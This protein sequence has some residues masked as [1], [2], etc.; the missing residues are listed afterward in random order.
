MHNNI[1]SD[2][3][4]KITSLREARKK[5]A[6]HGVITALQKEKTNAARS[7]LFLFIIMGFLS[8]FTL[9][10]AYRYYRFAFDPTFPGWSPV[11]ATGMAAVTEVGK[12]MLSYTALSA[13]F[14]GWM[15]RSYSKFFA[16]VFALTI[17]GAWYYWSY[18]VSTE[19]MNLYAADQIAVSLKQDPLQAK[20]TAATADIDAQIADLKASDERAGKMTTKRGKIAWTGQSTIQ[21]NAATLSTLNEQRMIIVEATTKEHLEQGDKIEAKTNVLADWVKRFGGY[22][23]WIVLLC[24]LGLI[25]YDKDSNDA[26]LSSEPAQK[27]LSKLAQHPEVTITPELIK[28]ELEKARTMNGEYA[29]APLGK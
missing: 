21:A 3:S 27:V 14:Y 26:T 12:V 15:F 5:G 17:S 2:L 28:I 10:M 24:I 25:F 18:N 9:Y 19:G 20:I 8:L 29:S 22:A 1:F 4:E 11:M 16:G 7:W 13:L 6:E 23:E